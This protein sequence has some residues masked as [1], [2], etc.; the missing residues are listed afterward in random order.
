MAA[1]PTLASE[2]TP[3]RAGGGQVATD[4]AASTGRVMVA[5]VLG[6]VA[7]ILPTFLAGAVAVQAGDELGFGASGLGLLVAVPFLV[8]AV[9]SAF[10]GRT[11]EHLG[12]G[13]T[14]RLT[15]TVAC[16]VALGIAAAPSYALMA[17]GLAGAGAVNAMTQPAANLLVARG[18]P[19]A[20]QG[21]AFGLKQS[22]MPG[23]TMLAGLA[24]PILALPFSWR[25]AYVGAAAIAATAAVMAPVDRA[26]PRVTRRTAG[27][28]PRPDVP[29]TPMVVLSIG[30]G[31]G[32]AAAGAL[33]AFVV[34][35]AVAAG[36]AESAAGY[37]LTI[38]SALGIVIRV[39]IGR[40]ADRR[41][42]GH[43]RVVALMLL[44]G[45]AAF[46]AY[47]LG[48]RTALI[49][50]TPIAF[51]FGWAWPGLFNFSVVRH[52]PTAP[53]AATGITQTGT[54][55]GAML[56][57]LAFGWIAD[58]AS[59]AAA[60]WVG[61]TWFVVAAGAMLVGRRLLRAHKASLDPLPT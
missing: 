34:S 59:Y 7:A 38:G 23:A 58:R 48:G 50:A 39:V 5:A 40:R 44:G 61:A 18:I 60:W 21:A 46:A 29:W 47:A 22:A 12:A 8:A 16:A 17:L 54:Y 55:V 52:N 19:P 31:F 25:W 53:A 26:V 49:A 10:L 4:G 57:P 33:A 3:D 43:L 42:G 36:I 37:V 6:T 45:A 41:D 28:A 24:V 35:A 27:P 2:A 13:R 1:S 20:R 15:S 30:V 11:T 14:L 51:G 9:T 56:G 32:A